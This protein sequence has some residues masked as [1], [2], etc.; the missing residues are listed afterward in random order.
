M[1]C[2]TGWD[3]TERRQSEAGH[4]YDDG[5]QPTRVRGQRRR[6]IDRSPAPTPP[7][8]RN[9]LPGHSKTRGPSHQAA[10]ALGRRTPHRGFGRRPFI[11]WHAAR[12]VSLPAPSMSM[13]H[14]W[15]RSPATLLCSSWT[16]SASTTPPSAAVSLEGG[17]TS[18]VAS[19]ARPS[20]WTRSRR[21]YPAQRRPSPCRPPASGDTLAAG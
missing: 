10:G 4:G 3:G 12:V 11:A 18:V 6:P 17:A 2:P 14:R 20:A 5:E 19:D 1:P 16:V 7:A 21:R 8:R 13:Y 15:P 9:S